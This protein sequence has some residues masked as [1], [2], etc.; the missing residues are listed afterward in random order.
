MS[1]PRKG[2]N[3]FKEALQHM[4][5]CRSKERH[6]LTKGMNNDF[7]L[8]IEGALERAAHRIEGHPVRSESL[9][10]KFRLHIQRCLNNGR[11]YRQ[12]GMQFR[13][14]SLG[15]WLT[16]CH[17]P[18]RDWEKRQDCH[19]DVMY[20]IRNHSFDWLCHLADQWERREIMYGGRK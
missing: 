19:R 12:C 3:L 1:K 14:I 8:S 9:A 11:T 2:I 10:R 5:P 20:A 7:T 15:Q 18:F 6:W 16:D 4:P 13:Y 17:K